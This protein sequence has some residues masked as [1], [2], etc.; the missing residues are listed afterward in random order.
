MSFYVP[1]DIIKLRMELFL[2]KNF[3]NVVCKV[4]WDCLAKV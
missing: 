1:L 3:Q 2:R 4:F